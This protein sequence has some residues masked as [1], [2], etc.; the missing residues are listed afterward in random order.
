[1]PL[2]ETRRY[3]Q[4]ICSIFNLHASP[5]AMFLFSSKSFLNKLLLS[6]CFFYCFW[7]QSENLSAIKHAE[8][9][10]AEKLYGDALPFYSILLNTHAK[11]D[12][13]TQL[14]LRLVTC[15]L[16][17]HQ[18]Q[19]AL[20]LLSPLDSPFYANQRLYFMSLA[21]RQL[22]ENQQA[23]DLLQQC[24]LNPNSQITAHFIALEKGYHCLILGDFTNA[25]KA[26]KSILQENNPSLPYYLA[27]LSLVKIY[28]MTD[29]FNLAQHTLQQLDLL[30]PLTSPLYP[31]KLYLEGMFFLAN[32][33]ESQAITHFE[34]LLAPTSP[35]NNAVLRNIVISY[36]R[37]ALK[38]TSPDQLQTTL[39]QAENYLKH[40]LK[41]SQD[42]NALLLCDLYLIK[43]KCLNDAQSFEQARQL[44]AKQEHLFDPNQRRLVLLK[45]AEAAPLYPDRCRIYQELLVELGDEVSFL[46]LKAW[47][48][49]GFNDFLEAVKYQKTQNLAASNP[50]FKQAA[51]TFK[52]VISL[53]PQITVVETILAIKYLTLSD[54]YQH[55][56]L[57]AW[58]RLDSLLSQPSSLKL[59]ENPQEIYCLLG[60]TALQLT[61]TD[62]LQKTK[63]RL[64]EGL[65][66]HPS[67]TWGELCLKLEGLICIQLE[68]WSQ[69]ENIFVRLLQDYPQT[70][71]GE[72]WFWR[73]FCADHLKQS[74]LRNAYLQNVYLQN[75]QSLYAPL[76]Y[77]HLYSYRDYMRGQRKAIKHLKNMPLLFPTHPL[78]VCAYYLMGLDHTKDHL[79]EEGQLLY[80]QDWTAAIE[81]FQQ[82][83]STFDAL[84]EKTGIPLDD[85]PYFISIRYQAQLERARANLEIARQSNGGKRQ[86]YLEYAE[87]VFKQLIQEFTTP[88]SLAM[89][90]L[91]KNTSY[92]K[93]WAEAELR[94]AQT[95]E[96]REKWQ[97]AQRCLDESLIHYQQ[98]GI[99]HGYGL[100]RV[101][102]KK[103]QLAQKQQ[104][105]L[106]ALHDYLKAEE[107]SQYKTVLSPDEKLELWIQ[108]SMCYKSLHQLDEAMR[109]L[110]KVINDD[111]IS[112]LRIKAMF[113]RAEIYELQGRP[114]LAH[115]QLEATAR[116]G[117][118][119]A[120][121]AQA[122][123][124]QFYGT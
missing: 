91:K 33:K 16:E 90:E 26:F 20:A 67:T 103:G 81:A 66:L 86:I 32:Q 47:F 124:E 59:L 48:L 50:H 108:Q 23:L 3:S 114:E 102:Y 18:P 58:A 13:N 123:L 31:Q 9:L 80:R 61:E 64:R 74:A 6:G 8:R 44:L 71:S 7:I 52:H 22:G 21:Y 62:T 60:W 17:E 122:K 27:Y 119:W 100:M 79:S 49:K 24:S 83:E 97:E 109:L 107:A 70:D 77:F 46:S 113:L 115:K 105:D 45:Q 65:A 76:A 57:Q 38:T 1:M 104:N 2:N 69:A 72:L 28:L 41:Y 96:E 42:E 99:A 29:Q 11:Q 56:G 82:A 111:V 39:S 101:W 84:Y 118:E 12:L 14:T 54:L 78:I 73:A 19:Q 98:A 95:Y 112:A 93:I 34:R 121:Q 30:L 92:P 10:F 88:H 63:N 36:L 94:L 25:E 40:L 51:E 110:S 116:K 106:A 43:A 89:Q 117:G 53:D 55:Q 87:E 15:Y 5:P 68:E 37:L 75:P 35:Y 120:Q 85:L 4:N